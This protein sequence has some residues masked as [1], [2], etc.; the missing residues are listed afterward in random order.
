VIDA[1]ISVALVKARQDQAKRRKNGKDVFG[2]HRYIT[3][4][5]SVGASS[6]ERQIG[7]SPEI[8]RVVCEKSVKTALK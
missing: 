6:L 7:G 3:R 4:T 1:G 8:G 5:I 2:M